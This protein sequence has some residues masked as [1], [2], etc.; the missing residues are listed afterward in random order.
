MKQHWKFNLC[1]N[2]GEKKSLEVKSL[3]S[4]S[5]QVYKDHQ[6]TSKKAKAFKAQG[7]LLHDKIKQFGLEIS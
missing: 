3:I 2:R 6:V 4:G 7:P 1:K 5:I